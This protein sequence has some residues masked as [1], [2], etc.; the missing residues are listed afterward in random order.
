MTINVLSAHEAARKQQY[1]EL[2]DSEGPSPYM[3]ARAQIREAIH[4]LQEELTQIDF[5]S[6]HQH[7]FDSE[8]DY[9]CH[10]GAD[11]RA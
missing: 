9:C 3:V 2:S 5:L 1:Y 6:T 11:G 4:R 10:C 8:S 7:E